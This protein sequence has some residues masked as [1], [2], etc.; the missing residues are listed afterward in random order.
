[1]ATGTLPIAGVFRQGAL[2]EP[3]LA[4]VAELRAGPL[5]RHPVRRLHL[6]V[7]VGG[8][9][10]HVVAEVEADRLEDPPTAAP[11]P[12]LHVAEVLDDPRDDARLLPHL[13]H[14]GGLSA[15]AGVGAALGQRAD[16]RPPRGRDD[17]DV[18]V[19]DDHAAVGALALS[20]HTRAARRGRA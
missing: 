3:A 12:V 10:R 4:R 9:P 14:G 6:V 5:E 16:A 7:V 15:L 2:D 11:V 19:A 20:R 1:M 18:A 13:A 17:E 8:V